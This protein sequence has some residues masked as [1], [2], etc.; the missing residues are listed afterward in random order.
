VATDDVASL[1]ITLEREDLLSARI[2]WF[3]DRIHC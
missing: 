2:E 3:G 1:N